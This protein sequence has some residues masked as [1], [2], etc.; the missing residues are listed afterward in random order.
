MEEIKFIYGG[1]DSST[2]LNLIVNEIKRGVLSDVSEITQD[3][4]ARIGTYYMGTRYAAKK[5]EIECT[6]KSDTE[7][8]RASMIHELGNLF[9]T[10]D[11]DEYELILSDEPQYVYHA[12]VTNISTP[13]RISQTNSWSKFTITFT[14]SIPY[15][16]GEQLMLN[17]D[18]ATFGYNVEGTAKT[19]PVISI[20]PKVDLTEIAVSNQDGDYVYLGTGENTDSS[21]E[22]VNKEPR[23]LHDE[24]N[25]LATWTK[26]T[27]DN[28]KFDME[29]VVIDS[30]ADFRSTENTLRIGNDSKGNPYFG[31][32]VK[33]KWH[34]AGRFLQLPKSCEDWQVRVRLYNNENSYRAKNKI[35]V[36]LLDE[37][38]NRLAKFM[39][40][41]NDNS[42]QVLIG[43]DVGSTSEKRK[44]ILG[45]R[46]KEHKA[47]SRKGKKTTATKTVKMVIKQKTITHAAKKGSHGGKKW[48]ETVNTYKTLKLDYD[49]T[50]ST[51]TDF[52]GW[53]QLRKVGDKLD[54]SY[55]KLESNG[56]NA[57]DNIKKEKYND[58]KNK[59]LSGKKLASIACVISKWDNKEDSLIGDGINDTENNKIAYRQNDMAL[60]DVVVWE[61][62]DGGNKK[63]S[64]PEVIAYAGEQVVIDSQTNRVY[65]DGIPIM[66][67]LNIG[68]TFFEDV[69]RQDVVYSF[70][71]TP[72]DAEIFIE[73]TPSIY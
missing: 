57:W 43:C 45:T 4:P 68:S 24:C 25:T 63:N 8:E 37:A 34:G 60:C 31:D 13:E 26:I 33:G 44:I 27:A 65:K 73:Y 70:Y 32:L 17:V 22:T 38:G 20:I 56:H 12:H 58:S 59:Y 3:I 40:K 54:L 19:Y 9:F 15:A 49:F 36:F 51:Y 55:M 1:F 64:Q 46:G 7:E 52:Y 6:M 67:A 48:K 30:K 28:L 10:D 66:S 35:E 14:C 39:L 69:G 62:I 21:T 18:T 11:D 61:I 2:E 5:I 42:R 41:D 50:Y 23:I 53:I 72:E 16:Y 71:P 47:S 29:N